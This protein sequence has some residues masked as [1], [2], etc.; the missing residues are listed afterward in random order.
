MS[1]KYIHKILRYTVSM[2]VHFLRHVL[3]KL[4]AYDKGKQ[5]NINLQVCYSKNNKRQKIT[6]LQLVNTAFTFPCQQHSSAN[7]KFIKGFY[8]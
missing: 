6:V 8:M 3:I 2:L 7:T 5:F 4:H 1:S